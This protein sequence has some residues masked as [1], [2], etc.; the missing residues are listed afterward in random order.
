MRLEEL[1]QEPSELRAL[2]AELHAALPCDTDEKAHAYIRLCHRIADELIGYL[3]SQPQTV[4]LLRAVGILSVGAIVFVALIPFFAF[5]EIGR[6]IGK[7]ELWSL[8]LTRGKKVYTL[9]TRPQQ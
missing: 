9:Q 4:E 3:Y 8:L 1:P 2:V 6:V 5:R 7:S